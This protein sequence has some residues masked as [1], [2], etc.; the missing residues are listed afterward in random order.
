MITPLMYLLS[1]INQEFI[2]DHPVDI[3]YLDREDRTIVLSE[4]TRLG[5]MVNDPEQIVLT[6]DLFGQTIVDNVQNVGDRMVEI[7]MATAI[8]LNR[9]REAYLMLQKDAEDALTSDQGDDLSAD[10]AVLRLEGN[11]RYVYIYVYDVMRS[12]GMTYKEKILHIA[13]LYSTILGSVKT[14]LDT[15]KQNFLYQRL[16]LQSTFQFWRGLVMSDMMRHGLG[17]EVTVTNEDIAVVQ[18]E[19]SNLG[20][21]GFV[22]PFKMYND[23]AGARV[24]RKVTANI[25]PDVITFLEKVIASGGVQIA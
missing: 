13:E 10:V 11:P 3:M 22:N 6:E 24:T 21:Y 18:Q 25:S 15:T 2:Y 4:A 16:E 1:G 20:F 14:T 17:A 9:V 7:N 5:T 23:F 12:R 8:V 19:L